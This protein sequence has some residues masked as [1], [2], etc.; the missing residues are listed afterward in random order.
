MQEKYEKEIEVLS[1]K[2]YFKYD[3]FN[4]IVEIEI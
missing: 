2:Q 4:E 3:D 1:N